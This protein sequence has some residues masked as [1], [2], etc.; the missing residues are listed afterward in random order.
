MQEFKQRIHGHEYSS[1]GYARK[2]TPR[3]ADSRRKT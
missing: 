1:P 2:W 3:A